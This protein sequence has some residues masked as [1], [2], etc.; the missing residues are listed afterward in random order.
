MDES[1]AYETISFTL[2]WI[3]LWVTL[4]CGTIALTLILVGI[5]RVRRHRAHS[6]RENR[7]VDPNLLHDTAIQRRIGYGFAVVAAAAAVMG[8][9]TFVQDRAAFEHN[10]KAKYP[11]VV[12]LAHVEQTGMSFTADVTYAD[13][14]TAERELIMVEPTGE[15]LMGEDILGEPGTGGR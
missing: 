9:V 14:T 8:V 10:V 15:P 2:P 4:I 12:E 1:I 11:D 5:V 7:N 6:A 13:G 3:G